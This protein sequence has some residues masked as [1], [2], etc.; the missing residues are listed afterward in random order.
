MQRLADAQAYLLSVETSIADPVLISQ[1]RMEHDRW[2]RDVVDVTNHTRMD[3]PFEISTGACEITILHH[4]RASSVAHISS[5]LTTK[6]IAAQLNEGHEK[7][8]D[9][10]GV[11]IVD[12]ME[13][14]LRLD[15]NR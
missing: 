4:C 2:E 3:N 12:A 8:G 9:R 11:S 1:W 6:M 10:H 14:T 13:V 7:A 15:D 5:G